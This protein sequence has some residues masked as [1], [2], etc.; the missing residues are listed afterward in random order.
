MRIKDGSLYLIITEEY[1]RGRSAVEI[2]DC[3]IAG[4]VDII[5]LREKKR[6]REEV[7][8]MAIDIAR[9]CA[10]RGVLFIINDDPVLAKMA[11]ADGVHLGK[12]D[13]GRFRVDEARKILGKGKIVGVSTSSVEDV[14]SANDMEIDYIGFGPVFPTAIKEGCVGTGCV[15]DVL[16]LA[17][18]P[19]FFIGGI[20]LKNIGKL[21]KKGARNVAVIRA[22]LEADNIEKE[23]AI[24]KNCL[25]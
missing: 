21:T 25:S 14:T 13:L 2:A 18:V 12:E 11:G 1:G 3:A 17:R 6:P 9:A 24:W 22:I 5:Q 15:G 16:G 23:V 7:L 8:P 4:G 20:A 10:K 19:V